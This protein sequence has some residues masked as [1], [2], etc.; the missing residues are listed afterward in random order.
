MPDQST[1]IV[2]QALRVVRPGFRL[3]FAGG[4]HGLPHWARVWVHGRTLATA[5]DL[6]PAVLAWFAFLHDSQRE[7]DG[8]D[9][10]HG[11]RAADVAVGL[12]RESTISGL[13]DL[14]FEQLC[15]A[16]C[17]H[18]DGHTIAEPTIQACWDSD[19]LDLARV[20]I[21]PHP[22]RLCTIP[23]RHPEMIEQAMRMST[24]RRRR[25][26]RAL[27]PKGQATA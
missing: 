22:Q 10:Q 27:H 7:N 26:D 9:A 21:R 20:G 8:R 18:S 1:S 6:N 3:D 5:L 14:E 11:Q 12:R 24:G 23:A 15:E 2:H 25:V 19:R 17:L 13:S 16:M 4:I